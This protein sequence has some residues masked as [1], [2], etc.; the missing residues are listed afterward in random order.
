[1][2][3]NFAVMELARQLT[4]SGERGRLYRYRTKDRLACRPAH[5]LTCLAARRSRQTETES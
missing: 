4:W 2:L 3:E 1:M 5:G